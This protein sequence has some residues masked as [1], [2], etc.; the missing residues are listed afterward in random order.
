[1]TL[2]EWA[3]QRP[4]EIV[5]ETANRAEDDR[6]ICSVVAYGKPTILVNQPT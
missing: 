2:S 4:D 3:A 1:M 5:A 6:A